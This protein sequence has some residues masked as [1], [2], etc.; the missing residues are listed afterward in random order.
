MLSPAAF[1]PKPEVSDLEMAAGVG[2]GDAGLLDEP[3]T[4]RKVCARACWYSVRSRW[5]CVR[6]WSLSPSLSSGLVSCVPRTPSCSQ[7]AIEVVYGTL[8][9]GASLVCSE[10]LLRGR[11]G[12][13]GRVW[14][15][16]RTL[17]AMYF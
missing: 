10:A 2:L 5:C 16:C 12:E 8:G 6:C 17:F 11:D 15:Y 14:A 3:S 13:E 1:Q 7:P 4:E 9:L